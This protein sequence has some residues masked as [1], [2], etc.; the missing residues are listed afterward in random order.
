MNRQAEIIL[1]IWKHTWW[2][3]SIRRTEQFFKNPTKTLN[4]NENSYIV[5]SVSSII[6]PVDQAINT[7][8]NH[9][10]ILITKQKLENVHHF[11]F[12]EA[13]ISEIEK[14]LGEI[15]S[16]KVTTNIPTKIL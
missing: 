6:G 1:V 4:I 7:Y 8:K 16:N 10:S 2:D 14:E 3:F 9:D 12:K 15:N 5:D 11:S 13:S